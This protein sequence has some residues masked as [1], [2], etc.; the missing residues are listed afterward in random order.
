MKKLLI[1]LAIVLFASEVSADYR[2]LE[3]IRSRAKAKNLA[4]KQKAQKKKNIVK[5]KVVKKKKI[6][7][8]K[9]P[10]VKPVEKI[11]SEELDIR[12]N[13]AFLPN[14]DIPFTGKHIENHPNGK[15]YIE[16]QYKDGK[17]DGLVLMWDEYGHKVGEIKYMNGQRVD[18]E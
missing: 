7:E 18:N 6:V 9:K 11:T 1:I 5:K 15:K 12:N 2:V 4:A 8:I 13:V 3:L 17:K 16:I 14:E 10:I